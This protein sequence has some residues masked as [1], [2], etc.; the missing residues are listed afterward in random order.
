LLPALAML[1]AVPGGVAVSF[2][3]TAGDVAK[4]AADFRIPWVTV[5]L[6]GLGVPLISASAAWLVSSLSGRRRR[7]LSALAL[8]AE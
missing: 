8:A 5:T 7:D 4:A 3:F 2:A 1:L 6:L